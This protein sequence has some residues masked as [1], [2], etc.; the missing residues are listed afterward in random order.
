MKEQENLSP[1]L[2]KYI[3]E[4]TWQDFQKYT[5]ISYII[6]FCFIDIVLSTVMIGIAEYGNKNLHFVKEQTRFFMQVLFSIITYLIGRKHE[7]DKIKSF[8]EN[9]NRELSSTLTKISKNP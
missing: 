3:R 8:L 1:Q 2:A 5:I 4:G 6:L 7:K 9:E